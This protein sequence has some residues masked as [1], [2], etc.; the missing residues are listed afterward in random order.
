[1]GHGYEEVTL[2]WVR[3][4]KVNILVDT[5]STYI[6]LPPEMAQE[7]GTPPPPRKHS[8]R[9]ADGREAEVEVGTVTVKVDGREAP[10]TAVLLPGAEPLL[11]VEAL[12]ALGLKVD[13]TTGRLEATRSYT[14]RA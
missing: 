13:P 12:E 6:V 10:A 9:L 8:V 4:R 2:A 14:I 3:E 7:L 11:G 1:M 5:G